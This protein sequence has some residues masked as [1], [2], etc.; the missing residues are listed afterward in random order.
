MTAAHNVTLPFTR[1]LIGPMDYTPGGFGNR[2]P[3]T[4]EIRNAPPLV[5]NTRGQAL[6]MYVVYE[7][8]L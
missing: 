7:S 6:A 2:T 4:F 3:E 1:M 5:Q 8:P